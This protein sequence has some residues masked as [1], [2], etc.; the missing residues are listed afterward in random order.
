VFQQS[1]LYNWRNVTE[2][3]LDALQTLDTACQQTDGEVSVQALTYQRLLEMPHVRM[4]CAL[5]GQNRHEQLVAVGWIYPD[6]TQALLQGKVHPQH[7]Q[8]GLGS[9][10]IHRLEEEAHGLQDVTTLIIRNEAFNNTCAALYERQ[11]YSRDFVEQWMERD[12][13]QTLPSLS[14]SY[15]H[16]SWTMQNAHQFFKVYIAAFKERPGFQNIL[17]EDWIA[18]YAEAPEFRDDL[19]L[20]AFVDDEA[21][22][23]VTSGYNRIPGR[24]TPVGWIWQIGVHPSMRKRAVAT[25]LILTVMEGFRKDGVD[26]LGLHVNINN[27]GAIHTYEQLGFSMIGQRAKYSKVLKSSAV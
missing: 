9:Y 10:L 13:R 26:T 18:D 6:R 2:N 8:K 23:F 4:I 24:D 1:G 5:E 17:A 3:D 11:G 15:K 7:R 19:S 14:R 22:G 25:N 20:L 16:Q 27:P 21:V 12:L